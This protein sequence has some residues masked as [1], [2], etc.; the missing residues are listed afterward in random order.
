MKIVYVTYKSYIYSL[1]V[2]LYTFNNF[3]LETKFMSTEPSESKT[4]YRSHHK[5]NL[6]LYGITTT[7][8]SKFMFNHF[9]I[10]VYLITHKHFTEKNY[11]TAEV[12]WE[13]LFLSSQ[14]LGQS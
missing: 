2:I 14:S 6:Q 9:L 4:Y 10:L 5:D 13:G 8:D 7:P 3:V 12:G 1:K 11:I